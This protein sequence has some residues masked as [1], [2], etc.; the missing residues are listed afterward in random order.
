MSLARRAILTVAAALA[1]GG[2]ML[3]SASAAP[4]A[5]VEDPPVEQTAMSQDVEASK[6]Y[7]H[8]WTDAPS[9]F[10]TPTGG[11]LYAGT[12]YFYC[13]AQGSSYSAHGYS[14]D[15][16]LKTDDDHGNTNVWVSA[17]YISGG[18]DYE[19]I[20]GVPEC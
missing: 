7:K 3:T 9:Y 5:Q 15:W 16:W 1:T 14:N 19:P 11:F 20:A 12:N 18:A 8:V 6:V 2:L 4:T 10:N 13:Q 17:V